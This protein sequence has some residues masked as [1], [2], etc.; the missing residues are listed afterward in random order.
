[1]FEQMMEIREFKEDGKTLVLML[2]EEFV[3]SA[4]L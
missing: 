1:M 4:K 2:E 3:L